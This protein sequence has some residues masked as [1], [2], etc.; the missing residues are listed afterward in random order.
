MYRRGS[1]RT[2]A[3]AGSS[4]STGISGV[5]AV[6]G[7][8]DYARLRQNIAQRITE[9]AQHHPQLAKRMAEDAKRSGDYGDV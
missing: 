5:S 7:V 4:V 1:T 2:G 6:D 9:V 3:A 8:E